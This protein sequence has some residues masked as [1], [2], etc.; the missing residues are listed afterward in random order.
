VAD[1]P[2]KLALTAEPNR[3]PGTL[4]H[5]GVDGPSGEQ[6]EIDAAPSDINADRMLKGSPCIF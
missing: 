6:R 3:A 4:D 5:L 1:P 2:R